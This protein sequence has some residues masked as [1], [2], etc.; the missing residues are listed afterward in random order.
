MWATD[1]HATY[2]CYGGN[3]NSSDSP[4]GQWSWYNINIRAD[5]DL[6]NVA[7]VDVLSRC[8]WTIYD[9]AEKLAHAC[10]IAKENKISIVCYWLL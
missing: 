7:R 1:V 3:R 8:E 6:V 4:N 9:D 10:E 2:T 5:R